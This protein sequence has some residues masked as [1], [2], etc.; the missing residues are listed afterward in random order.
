M[1]EQSIVILTA[2]F[3]LALVAVFVWLWNFIPHKEKL[4][5]LTNREELTTDEIYSH[6]FAGKNLPKELVL[7]LW[8]EVADSLHLPK[9]KLRPTDR[10]DKELAPVKGWEYDDDIAEVTWAAQH[11]LKKIGTTFDLSKIQTL[12]DYVEFFGRLQLEA[13]HIDITK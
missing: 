4:K 11:R 13:Q 1:T 6:F 3:A 5:R 8:N 12:G 2:V 10:F 7:K 9:G